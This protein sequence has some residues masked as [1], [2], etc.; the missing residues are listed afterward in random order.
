MVRLSLQRRAPDALRLTTRQ[1]ACLPY[2]E[3][4]TLKTVSTFCPPP[5]LYSTPLHSPSIPPHTAS[6]GATWTPCVRRHKRYPLASL[7]APFGKNREREQTR[8]RA[9]PGNASPWHRRRRRRGLGVPREGSEARSGSAAAR[10]RRTGRRGG[11]KLSPRRSKGRLLRRPHRRRRRRAPRRRGAGGRG[12]SCARSRRMISIS[13][14]K[15]SGLQV[16]C[17]PDL[18]H[19]WSS[20]IFFVFDT[21]TAAGTF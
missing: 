18:G 20:A 3:A 1:R 16:R 19:T 13:R 10:P 12:C 9:Q 17:M 7:R 14:W 4:Q 21:N 6:L 5:L 2:L 8:G 15:A 11:E